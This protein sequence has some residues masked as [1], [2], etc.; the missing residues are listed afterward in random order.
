MKERDNPP[1]LEEIVEEFLDRH[2]RGEKPQVAEYVDRFPHLA[3]QLR[4]SLTAL[5]MIEQARQPGEPAPPP[6]GLPE[7]VGDYRILREIGRGGMG[8]V[9][10]AEQQSLGRHVALKVLPRQG[11]QDR[12]R[13]RFRREARAAARLHH[14]NIVPVFEV[15][16]DGDHLFYAMQLIRGRGLDAVI[17]S[18]LR[19][20][21][22]DRTPEGRPLGPDGGS[23][24]GELARFL[25]AGH[26]P[27]EDLH[28]APPPDGPDPEYTADGP[29]PHGAGS[30]TS[31]S[32]AAGPTVL[33]G[34]S[35]GSDGTGSRSY[36]RS[37]AR[38]GVQAADALAHAHARGVI[39]RDVKP[40]NLLL[41]GSGVVWLTDFGL[42]KTEE[43]AFTRT[44]DVVGTLRYMAPERFDGVA[45][46][47]SEVYSLGLTLYELL[48]LEPAFDS[49]D[50][51][52]LIDSIRSAEP[53]PPRA[54]DPQVP[55]DLETVV[56]KAID[57]D[58]RKRYRS[59][60]DLAADLRRFLEGEPVRA[61]R[62]TLPE[63]LLK[64]VRRRPTA[65][66]VYLLLPLVVILAA[67]GTLTT[68]LWLDAEEAHRTAEQDRQAAVDAEGKARKAETEAEWARQEAERQRGLAERATYFSQVS[69]AHFEWLDNDVIQAEELLGKCRPG[70]RDWEWHYLHH[71][72]HTDLFT[73]TGG[74]RLNCVAYSPD[75]RRI[76]AGGWGGGLFV[77]EPDAGGAERPW[78]RRALAGQSKQ[79]LC[80]AFSPDGQRIVTGSINS[81][82]SVWDVRTGELLYHLEGHT[83]S[84]E[85]VCY[86]PD[87]AL[88]ATASRD[89]TAKLWDAQT[90]K[91]IR[92]LKETDRRGAG[93][94]SFSPSGKQLL[95]LDWAGTLTVQDARTGR[96]LH[97]VQLKQEDIK[98]VCY[99]P[100]GKRLVSASHR[101]NDVKV[102]DTET[103]EE[104]FTL[105]LPTPA[106]VWDVCY[107]P[108]GQQ[109]ALATGDRRVH[110]W[111]A[112]TGQR[113]RSLQGHTD[114]VTGVAYRPDG[115][116]LV[117]VSFDGTAKI[118]DPDREQRALTITA[119]PESAYAVAF[120]P[121]GKWIASSS[122]DRTVKVWDATR[123]TQFLTLEGHTQAVRGVSFS[124]DGKRIASA[125]DDRTV[126]VWDAHKGTELLSLTGHTSP[127]F[128]VAFC[129][130]GNRLGSASGDR[131]VRLWDADSGR[132]VRN[133]NLGTPAQC[134]AFSPDGKHLAGGGGGYPRPGVVKVWDTHTGQEVLQLQGHQARVYEVCFSPDGQRI[135]TASADQTV[136]VWDARTGRQILRPLI[137]HRNFVNCVAFSPDGERLASGGWDGTVR[138]WDS[139]SG[140]EVLSL[141]T[142]GKV[143]GVCF[144]P[145]GTKLASTQDPPRAPSSVWV[146]EAPGYV[147][148]RNPRA[149]PPAPR[150]APPPP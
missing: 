77:W 132:E 74:P 11:P 129:P 48:T 21:V 70:W 68:H 76:V 92:T 46:I 104:V 97:A 49:S 127:V 10:E 93:G 87:G 61:R 138:L 100:D 72:C 89:Q 115:Q 145:D 99:S 137:G 123:G 2:R 149:L 23:S 71:L 3:H 108:D 39:H 119:H 22:G 117:S 12:A 96:T 29:A 16:E 47:R 33:P 24:P 136:R 44:G 125:S 27:T 107:R 34:S 67:V 134:V 41:D 141:R 133:W 103:W 65:A 79:I 55:R 9:Y 124:P 131:T 120:S 111:D 83:A 37:V 28:E 50:R 102:W 19:F 121:D 150:G 142:P 63:R 101:W 118:W 64:W 45:D 135:V 109:V 88:I 110:V 54:A 32:F 14:T 52:R 147:A 58:P 95:S 17:D 80:V 20:R 130:R 146:W 126:K 116:R 15:G 66:A 26:F 148:K 57:K 144:S 98:D 59:A 13:A 31:R 86:S 73:L 143:Q 75:G 36:Y 106:Y 78:T 140:E 62:T 18:L 42:A 53:P 113:L 56:L 7:Q 91:E 85:K 122:R 6:A 94:I 128:S 84:V 25:V 1:T 51:L 60:E 38:L 112:H 43:D 105:K 81:E 114:Q 5:A 8:I 90:G 40:S 4:R 82:V 35:G 30:S 139:R 69:R